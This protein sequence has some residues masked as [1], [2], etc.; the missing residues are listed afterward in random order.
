MNEGYRNLLSHAVHLV[1]ILETQGVRFQSLTLSQ[2]WGET[3]LSRKPLSRTF[4]FSY[5]LCCTRW[6][7]LFSLWTKSLSV[8]IQV[9]AIE[10]CFPYDCLLYC[11]KCIEILSL[12]TDGG[13][14]YVAGVVWAH[15]WGAV[16]YSLICFT[17][18]FKWPFSKIF[19]TWYS[20][21]ICSIFF[22]TLLRPRLC[23]ICFL[24]R[25]T[26]GT[27]SSSAFKS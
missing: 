19:Q 9:K 18:R 15:S 7:Q 1:S 26:C 11:V 2:R 10:Q 14:L 6:M 20:C 22:S 8:V 4:Q 24:C 12:C 23:A 16:H 21:P 27:V 5:W 13:L 25:P 17:S 3:L